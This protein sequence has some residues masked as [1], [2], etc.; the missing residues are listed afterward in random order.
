MNIDSLP[1]SNSDYESA[2]KAYKRLATMD[3][4]KLSPLGQRMR[5]YVMYSHFRALLE[6]NI[7][8]TGYDIGNNFNNDWTRGLAELESALKD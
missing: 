2:I 7:N 8:H 6:H 5:L 1:Y 4:A 3:E